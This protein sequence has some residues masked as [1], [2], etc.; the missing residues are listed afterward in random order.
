MTYTVVLN[1][2]LVIREN[3]YIQS[4]GK[5]VCLVYSSEMYVTVI[6]LHFIIRHFE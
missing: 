1:F 4:K 3:E 5:S 6:S 2:I